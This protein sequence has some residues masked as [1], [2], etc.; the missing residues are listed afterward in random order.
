MPPGTS[1][2]HPEQLQ[3]LKTLLQAD[4]RYASLAR[5]LEGPSAS[6]QVDALLQLLRVD[7]CYAGLLGSMWERGRTSIP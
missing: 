4:H 7:P 5:L 6:P 2:M 1:A 3:A